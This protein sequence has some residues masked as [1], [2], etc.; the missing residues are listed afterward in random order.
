MLRLLCEVALRLDSLIFSHCLLLN[1]CI[2]PL[3]VRLLAVC[4]DK[5]IVLRGLPNLVSALLLG[6]LSLGVLSCQHSRIVLRLRCNILGLV[7]GV[8]AA[9]PFSHLLHALFRD[10][11][12]VLEEG[13]GAAR[14]GLHKERGF[15][16]FVARL[17]TAIIK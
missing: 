7:L 15:R 8:V 3:V 12:V 14:R 2:V 9:V 11:W 6:K 17:A 4:F 13:V 16:L 5:L 1:R 10:N